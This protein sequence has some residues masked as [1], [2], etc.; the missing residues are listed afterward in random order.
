VGKNM[1]LEKGK[2]ISWVFKIILV[3]AVLAL[4]VIIGFLLNFSTS[5]FI[6]LGI[7]II[8]AIIILLIIYKMPKIYVKVSKY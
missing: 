7:G 2:D 6:G 8:A 1:S 4:V 5:Y 3:V